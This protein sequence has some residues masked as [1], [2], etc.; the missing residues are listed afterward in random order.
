MADHVS[1]GKDALK[2]RRVMRAVYELSG[3]LAAIAAQMD[4]V[5]EV[6]ACGKVGGKNPSSMFAGVQVRIVV[7][8]VSVPVTSWDNGD[9]VA[10]SRALQLLDEEQDRVGLLLTVVLQWDGSEA[11]WPKGVCLDDPGPRD[12]AHWT[13]RFTGDAT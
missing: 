6:L 13:A 1:I 9:A 11:T 7:G 8:D 5:A 4:S 12:A 3:R 2:N 10:A